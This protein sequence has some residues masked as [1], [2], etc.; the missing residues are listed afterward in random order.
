MSSALFGPDGT[1]LP[2]PE[3]AL[4]DPLVAPTATGAWAAPSPF[5]LPPLPPM[6]DIE[7]IRRSLI[8]EAQSLPTPPQGF[9]A[10]PVYAPP[11]FDAAPGY[12]P[13]PGFD[14][15]P[16]FHAAPPPGVPAF[17]P[18]VRRPPPPVAPS[19]QQR[20]PPPLSVADQLEPY[21]RRRRKEPRNPLIQ[22]RRGSGGWIGCVVALVFLVAIGFNLVQALVAVVIDLV[23]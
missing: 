15:Q 10:Q 19:T 16:G 8:E 20:R 14:A 17:Q 22:R 9:P 12:R 23:S 4:P 18:G 2:E 13:A 3:H 1:Q 5:S 21:G 6:P 11:A 7:A